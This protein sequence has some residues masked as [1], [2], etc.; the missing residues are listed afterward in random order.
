MSSNKPWAIYFFVL[1]VLFVAGGVAFLIG[2]HYA[3]A[4]VAFVSSAVFALEGFR[5]RQPEKSDR[6]SRSSD[7][8]EERR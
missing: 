2:E 1:S 6:D 3:V 5:R 7:V 4:G 8:G